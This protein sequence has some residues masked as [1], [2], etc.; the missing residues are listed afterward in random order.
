MQFALTKHVPAKFHVVRKSLCPE[1]IHP[2]KEKLINPTEMLDCVHE[3]LVKDGYFRIGEGLLASQNVMS[4]RVQQTRDVNPVRA[5]CPAGVTGQT[6]PYALGLNNLVHIPQY[7]QTNKLMRQKIHLRGHR[8][9]RGTF[10][11]LI[12]LIYY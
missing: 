12:A 3:G 11:A 9:T 6:Q 2:H 7:R 5:P 10:T 4:D 1:F 8:T